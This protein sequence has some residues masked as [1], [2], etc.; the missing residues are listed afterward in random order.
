MM[1][2]SITFIVYFLPL[3]VAICYVLKYRPVQNLFL[4]LASLVFYAWGDVQGT[5]FLLCSM[6]VNYLFGVAIANNRRYAKS[7]MYIG[8]AFNLCGLIYLKYIGFL[9]NSMEW[10]MLSQLIPSFALPLGISFYTLL[11][12]SYLIEVYRRNVT[13][14]ENPVNVGLYLSFFPTVA[15][16]PII[17]YQQ[18]EPQL[19]RRKETTRTFS[20]GLCRFVLG[21]GKKLL[22]AN[23]LAVVADHV[24]AM[25]ASGAIPMS[26][27]WLGAISF[28]LQIFFDF[29]A[30]SDM[31]IGLGRMLGFDL[32]ENFNYPYT[33]ATMTEFWRRWHMSLMGWFKRY[34]FIPL[35]GSRVKNTDLLIYNLF[36]VWVL[37]GIWHGVGWNFFLWGLLQFL[38]IAAERLLE[39]F[40]RENTYW[41]QYIYV[42]FFVCISWT[43]FRSESL[44]AAGVY[45]SSL[46]GGGGLWSD[47]VWM[48]LRENLLTYVLAFL[49]M[50]PVARR[51]NTC[52]V[53]GVYERYGKAIMVFYPLFLLL[54]FL[55]SFAVLLKG[56]YMNAGL[57][58]VR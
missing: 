11:A 3:V 28:A 19:L 31:A 38:A 1:F 20:T 44:L 35:G 43:L 45:F 4:L 9:L 8:I 14:P 42:F 17:G 13:Y 49:F 41:W 50:T 52:V 24:F 5:V 36:I 51:F 29:S 40:D 6:G 10:G 46:F 54:V 55:L 39:I 56:P 2:S 37:I 30:Y 34:V 32:P 57:A 21:L 16:G 7:I 15:A 53:N 48:F 27:A 26:L 47:Y 12:I 33:A 23:N 22:I 18:F 58:F 25:S